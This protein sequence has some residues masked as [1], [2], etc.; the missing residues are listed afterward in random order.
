MKSDF[1]KYFE[2]SIK[3]HWDLM[4]MTDYVSKKS[5]TYQQVGE[6]ISKLHIL[7]KELNIAQNDRIALVGR[8]TPEW[9]ITFIA[10]VTYGAVIVPILQDFHADDI[11]H[12]VNHSESKLLFLSDSHWENLNEKTIS[13]CRKRI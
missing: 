11:Q 1:I 9:A 3:E 10:T 4:A 13:S 7:F 12:I 5:Y 8:N 2:N 6:E